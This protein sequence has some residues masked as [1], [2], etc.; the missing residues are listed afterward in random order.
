M[1]IVNRIQTEILGEEEVRR[2]TAEVEKQEAAFRK[3]AESMRLQGA[4]EAQVRAATASIAQNIAG[5]NQKLDEA[6]RK[7]GGSLDANGIRNI[8]RIAQD[9]QYGFSA[10]SNNIIEIAPAAG[11]VGVGIQVISANAE[12]AAANIGKWREGLD[13][14][15]QGLKDNLSILEAFIGGMDLSGAKIRA[16][17]ADVAEGAGF[18]GVGGAIRGNPAA[19]RL[20]K[21]TDDA[22]EDLLKIRSNAEKERQESLK[23]T[24]GEIGGDQFRNM[25]TKGLGPEAAGEMLRTVGQALGT[26]D[27][28]AFDRIRMQLSKGGFSD[29]AFALE[30]NLPSNVQASKDIRKQFEDAQ[31]RNADIQERQAKDEAKAAEAQAKQDFFS[32]AADIFGVPFDE[33]MGEMLDRMTQEGVAKGDAIVRKYKDEDLDSRAES[34]AKAQMQELARKPQIFQGFESFLAAVQTAGGP[35]DKANEYLKQLVELNRQILQKDPAGP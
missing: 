33:T 18:A 28:A 5:L 14:S 16:A 19:E 35:E 24:I 6:R 7:L 29:A 23:A 22:R 26:G 20:K 12:A 8:G 31:K 11:L 30:R 34:M 13:A 17:F 9:A 2:Y 32:E 21:E 25:L 15:Q 27:S 4:A 3:L 1:D 10:I